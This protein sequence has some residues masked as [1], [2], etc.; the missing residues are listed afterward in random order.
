MSIP[1]DARLLI[2][3]I[4]AVS[5]PNGVILRPQYDS[6]EDVDISK[7]RHPKY[8][9]EELGPV[10]AAR[11]FLNNKQL[12]SAVM[13]VLDELPEDDLRALEE[14][15][16]PE[17]LLQGDMPPEDVPVPLE[18]LNVTLASLN[19]SSDIELPFPEL[20]KANRERYVLLFVIIIILLLVI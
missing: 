16:P 13:S 1:L 7:V 10:D 9:L 20:Q 15:V 11:V 12:H 6:E 19:N 14:L 5:M 4:L 8:S 18:D 17:E 3:L 2:I